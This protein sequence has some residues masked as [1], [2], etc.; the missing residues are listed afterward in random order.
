MVA[1]AKL[2][3][4]MGVPRDHVL[5]C[6]D[7]D[8]LELSDTGLQTVG[9][10]PA[11]FLYVDGIVGDVGQ[12]VLRDRKVLAEERVGEEARG[13]MLNPEPGTS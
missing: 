13:L 8:V 5:V 3:M 4:L 7:G 2:G 10:V 1:N 11:G 12:G 9:R 6:E